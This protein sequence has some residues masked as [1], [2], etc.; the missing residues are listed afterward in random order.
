MGHA[1]DNERGR[2]VPMHRSGEGTPY[3]SRENPGNFALRLASPGVHAGGV[4]MNLI[5]RLAL[6]GACGA[7]LAML[8]VWP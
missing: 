8:A 6:L 7:F 4:S 3:K 2:Q 1:Q 5:E